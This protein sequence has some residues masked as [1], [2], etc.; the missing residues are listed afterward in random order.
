MSSWRP[1][2]RAWRE[3]ASSL[4]AALDLALPAGCAGCGLTGRVLCVACAG[5]LHATPRPAWPEPAPAGLPVPWAV[6]PY[7]GV[8]R[9]VILAHKEDGCAA[10]AAP[11]GEAAARS[12][13]AALEAAAPSADRVLLVPMPS[14][15]PAIRRRGRD[16][17][18]AIARAAARST[19]RDGHRS[20][21]VA[22]VLRMAASV[23]D[24]SGLAAQARAANLRDAVLLPHRLS[25]ALETARTGAAAVVVVDDI[26]TT[27]ASLC[28][29]AET[30]RRA[31]AAPVGAALVAATQR[32]TARTWD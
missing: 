20:V 6:A 26:V 12:V 11:L 24:Q 1:A 4:H 2:G 29:A 9:A 19:R 25:P 10:L 30:L 13:F 17:T 5:A 7:A 28:A 27:G 31:G 23:S 3:L 16:P 15:R 14:R 21:V 22:P 32:R 18:L 8:V